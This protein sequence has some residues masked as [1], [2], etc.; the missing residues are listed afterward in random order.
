MFV[1]FG[2]GKRT[3]KD[4]G[5]TEIRYCHH[6][7]NERPWQVATIRTWFTL[8]FI[9][10]IPYSSEHI[11]KCPICNSYIELDKASFNAYA[12]KG[13]VREANH[14]NPSMDGLTETQRNY[15]MQMQ[16]HREEQ[17]QGYDEK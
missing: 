9:P 2:F 11:A 7:H 10:V 14:S 16:A 1:L 13:D 8:F 17:K 3:V 4:H 15:R 5:T 12:G 6:C